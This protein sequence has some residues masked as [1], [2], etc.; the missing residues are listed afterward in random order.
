MHHESRR[1]AMARVADHLSVE[2]LEARLRSAQDPTATRHFQVIWLLARGHTIAD[3]AA[4]TSF[5]P[6]WIEQLLARYNAHGPEALGDLRRRNGGVR[7]V[8]RPALLERLRAA[9]GAAARWGP[10][11]QPQSG[12]LD[13]GRTRA[14]GGVAPTWLGGPEGDQLV[15][16]EAAAPPSGRGHARGAGGGQTKLEQAVAGEGG[17][18]PNKPVEVW[19][20]DEHRL[21]LKPILRRVWA[22]KGQRPIALGH[23]R[24]KWLYVTAF[25]QPI[26]GEVFWSIST[27]VSKPFFA[28][29]LALFAREAGAGQDRIVVLGLDSAG[30]H[31]EPN[32]AVPE[33]IRLVYLPPYSPELQPAEH[34]WPILDEPLA[35]QYFETLADLEHVVT[36]RCRVLNGDQLKPGTNFHW[37]PKPATP[38]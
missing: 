2:D 18:N 3:V 30:W 11:V 26:S 29:L 7:G 31:T 4:V 20:T 1:R 28:A 24:Y 33:G 9:R 37:W 15:G 12:G 8:L 13:G 21:G 16:A 22:P 10:V 23:H 35:N 36:E 38:V 5:G 14:R 34:L 17:R 25:V 27:G 32:L 19:A 6:R